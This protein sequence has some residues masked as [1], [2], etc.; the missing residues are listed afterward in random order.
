MV[1]VQLMPELLHNIATIIAYC[2]VENSKIPKFHPGPENINSTLD[3]LLT[4]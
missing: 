4:R 2:I 1:P 3:V